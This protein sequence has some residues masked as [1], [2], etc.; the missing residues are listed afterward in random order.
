[1]MNTNTPI[2]AAIAENARNFTLVIRTPFKS[3]SRTYQEVPT[4]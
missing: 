4:G 1:V 3:P 2:S